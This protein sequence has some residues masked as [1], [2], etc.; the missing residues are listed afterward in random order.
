[1]ANNKKT[2]HV[3]SL[4]YAL[5]YDFQKS[6]VS[7]NFFFNFYSTGYF[8]LKLI[9]TIYQAMRLEAKDLNGFS[10]PYIKIYLLPEMKKKFQTRT[11]RK[12]LNPVYNES[13]IFKVI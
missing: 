13:F 9:V 7:L 2:H 11:I 1:M 12:T 3:G 6:E 5:D 8:I 10:D 4:E